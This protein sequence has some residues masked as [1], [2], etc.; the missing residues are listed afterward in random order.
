MK[1]RNFIRGDILTNCYFL[2]PDRGDQVIVIDPGLD[3]KGIEQKLLEK[4]LK[5]AYILLTHGHFDHAM[6]AAY[7]RQVTGAKVVIHRED[8]ELLADPE[9]NAAWL[10]Y[11]HGMSQYPVC[12]ADILVSQGDVIGLEDI[13][14]RVVHTP[15][16]TNGSICLDTGSDLF[17]GDTLFRG[18]FGR[19]DLYGGDEKR[20]ARS[21]QSLCQFPGDRK[22]YP[23]H[24]SSTHLSSERG[25][26]ERF[27]AYYG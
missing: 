15:G 17:T 8:E 1:I 24:G 14:L 25:A 6:G 4:N 12:P 27:V 19:T 11:G 5:A 20:L 10:Y 16:H 3:G 26:M 9:K 23:G 22:V 7:L 21:L 2:I 13:S 18:D